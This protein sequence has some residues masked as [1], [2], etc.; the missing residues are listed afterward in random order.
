ME[1]NGFSLIKIRRIRLALNREG[2]QRAA[3]EPA[4]SLPHADAAPEPGYDGFTD[5]QHLLI[6]YKRT[7]LGFALAGLTAAIL[8]VSLGLLFRFKVNNPALVAACAAIG[9]VAFPLLKPTFVF[10]Q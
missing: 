3:A 10:V 2:E 1:S 5:Y 7:V 8:V 9:V 6:P 4:V